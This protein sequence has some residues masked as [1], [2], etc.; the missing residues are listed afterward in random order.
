MPIVRIRG[1]SPFIPVATVV[2]FIYP[3]AT[4]GGS[5]AVGTSLVAVAGTAV[6]DERADGLSTLVGV[7]MR[8]EVGDG[9]IGKG[10]EFSTWTVT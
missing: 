6:G 9:E 8:I 4:F 5:V 10:W 1:G 3:A 2:G 7:A